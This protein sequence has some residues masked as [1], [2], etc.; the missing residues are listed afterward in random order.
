[1]EGPFLCADD[2]GAFVPRG[3]GLL[4]S[5]WRYEYR[6]VWFI[7]YFYKKEMELFSCESLRILTP[8]TCSRYVVDSNGQPGQDGTAAGTIC[9]GCT[10]HCAQHSVCIGCPA[11][12]D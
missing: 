2:S 9:T 5:V 6:C 12:L 4:R 11:A 8:S 3:H 7:Q 10:S 1:M